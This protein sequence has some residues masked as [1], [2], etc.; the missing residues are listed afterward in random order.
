MYVQEMDR[1]HEK[2]SLRQCRSRPSDDEW[3]EIW[4]AAERAMRILRER[5]R[6]SVA[7][8]PGDATAEHHGLRIAYSERGRVL[9]LADDAGVFLM[10]LNGDR[11]PLLTIDAVGRRVL[12]IRNWTDDRAASI[13]VHDFTPGEWLKAMRA[14]RAAGRPTHSP[15]DRRQRAVQKNGPFSWPTPPRQPRPLRG[16]RPPRDVVAP[17]GR[18]ISGLPC[19]LASM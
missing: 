12:A 7:D 5:G 4:T 17:S 18:R 3:H 13:E 9:P 14:D 10:D 15:A 16:G 19:G 2:R 1:W 6:A 8:T 11:R